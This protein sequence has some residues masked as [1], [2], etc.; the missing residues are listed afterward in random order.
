[1]S[2]TP[3]LREFQALSSI[4]EIPLLPI[5]LN[6]VNCRSSQYESETQSMSKLPQPL[7]QILKSSYNESQLQAISLAT[8]PFD[9]TKD[10][11]LTLI[12]GPP[13]VWLFIVF[14]SY[15]FYFILVLS[16]LYKIM[17]FPLVYILSTCTS[18]P[19]TGKTRTILAIVSSLLALSQMNDSKRLRNGG[20][21]CSNTGTSQRISQSAAIAR[22]WQDAALAR[23]LNEDVEKNNRSTGSG[24]R[25]RILICA[26]SNAAVDELVA[27]IYNE[28][29]YGCDGQRYKPYLVRVGN[30]K[31][32]HPNSLP[33]FID[34]LVEN[35]LGDEKRNAHDEKSGTFADSLSI[36][37]TN[38]EKLVEQIRYYEAKRASWQEENSEV[39]D[40]VEGDLEDGKTYS[41]AELKGKLRQLYEKKKAMYMDL[42]SA[43]ARERK[44]NEEMRAL[45]HKFRNAILKEA[46]IVVTTLSGCGGDLYGVCSESTSSH[47]FS[48]AS[49]TTLFDAVVIDEA[50]QVLSFPFQVLSHLCNLLYLHLSLYVFPFPSSNYVPFL[51]LFPWRPWNLPL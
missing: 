9:L 10:F 37:R 17:G 51:L 8:G 13:G 16:S 39:K 1:M 40:F 6:P 35:R 25:G 20:P 45:R 32:V 18:A 27:R 15:L 21:A 42:A 5:I 2:I 33:F 44:A 43:Q 38:L 31:T 28:G 22:A 19:G 24:S 34:T 29:L 3:Q 41:D 49:E 50:A 30:A 36:L 23:Q 46:E 7:Q 12:Q 11:E 14:Q 47:K 26:Q 48:N 4:R